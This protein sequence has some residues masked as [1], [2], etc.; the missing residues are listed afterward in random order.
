MILQ[1]IKTIDFNQTLIAVLFLIL[2]HT[3]IF[4]IPKD[5]LAYNGFG[6]LTLYKPRII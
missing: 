1:K 4:A 5:T 3:V 2:F 6:Y